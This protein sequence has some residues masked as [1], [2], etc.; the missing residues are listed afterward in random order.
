MIKSGVWMRKSG[1]GVYCRKGKIQE[2]ETRSREWVGIEARISSQE[3]IIRR[4]VENSINN[5][6]KKQYWQTFFGT[7]AA[8]LLEGSRFRGVFFFFP[9]GALAAVASCEWRCRER[10]RE[11]ER[12]SESG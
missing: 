2:K 5:H 6:T 7:R 9:N 12:E 3:R 4:Q 1:A 8:T 11:R 10:E